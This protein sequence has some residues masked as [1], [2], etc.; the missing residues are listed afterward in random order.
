MFFLDIPEAYKKGKVNFLSVKI[1]V[2]EGVFIPREE[3]EFWVS[4]AIEKLKKKGFEKKKIKFLDIFSGSGCIGISLLVNFKNSFVTFS[5]I[6][7][8][9]ILQIKENL[10][11]NK[12]DPR[13]Y[14]VLKSN[15][16]EEISKKYDFIFANPPYVALDRKNEVQKSVLYYEPPLSIFAGKDGLLIIRK[17]LDQ[18]KNYLKKEGRIYLEFDP[19]QKEEI[20][21]IIERND[22]SRSEF[23]RDQFGKWR[24]VEIY[25]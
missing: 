19:Y 24:W 7:D 22:F 3:T 10:E 21:S 16:F 18:A 12:L 4:K 20:R 15:L 9:A 11:E 17:F 23:Y 2:R 1:K 8:I 13:R 14:E 5:D 25:Y 6:S